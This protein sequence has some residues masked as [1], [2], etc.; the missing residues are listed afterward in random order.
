M[1]NTFKA[2]S[3][4]G[5]GCLARKAPSRGTRVSGLLAPRQAN[6][7]PAEAAGRYTDGAKSFHADDEGS[8]PFTR[9]ILNQRL[10]RN[11]A[12][13]DALFLHSRKGKSGR[14]ERIVNA[15]QD[16]GAGAGARHE[17]A[18]RA[19]RPTSF[20]LAAEPLCGPPGETFQFLA[21]RP[22]GP[23]RLLRDL[24]LDSF[25]HDLVTPPG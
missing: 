12:G 11:I 23:A 9:S 6:D 1:L 20:C 22:Q 14:M 21:K 18:A 8:I 13:A 19:A 10:V 24:R 5:W 4:N 15:M 7:R 3:P 2:T 25:R 16:G 17:A